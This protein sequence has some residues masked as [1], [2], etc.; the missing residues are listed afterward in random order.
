MIVIETSR[1]DDNNWEELTRFSASWLDELIMV[2]TQARKA[3]NKRETF[4]KRT[5]AGGTLNYF[6]FKEKPDARI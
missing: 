4:R 1:D 5:I 3:L 2:L 6:E